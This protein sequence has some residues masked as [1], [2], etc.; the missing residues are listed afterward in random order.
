[1]SDASPADAGIGDLAREAAV[2]VNPVTDGE[3]PAFRRRQAYITAVATDKL[4]ASIK[5]PE[6]TDP[7]PN[8]KFM[9][10][11][12]IAGPDATVWVDQNGPDTV[13]SSVVGMPMGSMVMYDLADPIP[14]GWLICDGRSTSGWPISARRANTP[15]L[16]DRFL[17]GAGGA[18]AFGATGG[19]AT[20]TDVASHTHVLNQHQHTQTAHTHAGFNHNHSVPAH[21]HP[22]NVTA[23]IGGGTGV[24]TDYDDDFS[25]ASS[26]PQGINTGHS[27]AGTTGSDGSAYTTGSG[28]GGLTNGGTPDGG[29]GNVA[30]TGVSGGI[31][32][33]PPYYA[34]VI[35]QKAY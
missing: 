6:S 2:Q 7:I 25:G 21:N 18:Y 12:M 28:G 16:R 35:I 30:S 1:V 17:V 11:S 15:D 32:N 3:T 9:H 34:V 33:R 27:A 10:P 5:F 8:V 19:A 24:R 14:Y 20:T 4:S 29:G 13:V 22:Q 31:E 26:F 23:G